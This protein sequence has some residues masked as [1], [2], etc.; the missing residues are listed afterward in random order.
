MSQNRIADFQKITLPSQELSN[1][2]KLAYLSSSKYL[3]SCM[4]NSVISKRSLEFYLRRTYES[5]PVLESF[6]FYKDADNIKLKIFIEGLLN[7]LSENDDLSEGEN[8][9]ETFKATIYNDNSSLVKKMRELVTKLNSTAHTIKVIKQTE[10]EFFK[11]LGKDL[12]PRFA[13][14]KSDE[15]NFIIQENANLVALIEEITKDVESFLE[16]GQ[17]S[18]EPDILTRIQSYD[19]SPSIERQE[20]IQI[21]DGLGLNQISPFGKRFSLGSDHK[22]AKGHSAYFES[23]LKGAQEEKDKPQERSDGQRSSTLIQ[24]YEYIYFIPL[25]CKATHKG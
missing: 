15:L 16:T 6:N 13:P 20:K 12:S 9:F 18:N 24:I 19:N 8:N 25:I 10:E 22:M 17:N 21:N 14:H 3:Q 7:F 4:T 2:A 23:D 11:S 1:K 5:D